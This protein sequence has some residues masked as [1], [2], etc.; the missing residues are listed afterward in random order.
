MALSIELEIP[1][2]RAYFE[3]I[4][5]WEEKIRERLRYSEGLNEKRIYAL[6]HLRSYQWR[7]KKAYGKK[8]K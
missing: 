7:T 5:D 6:E 2:L 8:I 4:I 1:S 3:E